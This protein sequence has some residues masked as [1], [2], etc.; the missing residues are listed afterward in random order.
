MVQVLTEEEYLTL[1]GAGAYLDVCLHEPGWVE[2]LGVWMTYSN[3][4]INIIYTYC[5]YGILRP[6]L[7]KR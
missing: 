3:I 2:Y 1:N 6:Y 5:N 4:V 7:A